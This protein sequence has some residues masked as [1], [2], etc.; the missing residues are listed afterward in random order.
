[1]LACMAVYVIST[2]VPVSA[3]NNESYMEL[4]VLH[5]IWYGFVAINLLAFKYFFGFKLM[6][7]PVHASGVSYKPS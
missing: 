5:H 7:L 3:F 1:M 2:Y 4:G 6:Q